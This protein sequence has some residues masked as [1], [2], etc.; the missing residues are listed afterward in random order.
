METRTVVCLSD[1]HLRRRGGLPAWCLRRLAEAD[2]ILHAGDLVA[3]SLLEELMQLAPVTA[4]HGNMDA[5]VLR[6]RLPARDVIEIGGVKI[7]LLHDPGPALGRSAR[8]AQA[9]VGCDAIVYGHTH[10]PEIERL[11][12]RLILNPGSPTAPRST[13]GATMLE[14]TISSDQ[15]IEPVFI[16][17]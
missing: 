14:L 3:H 5:P 11:G 1:T 7:G 13:L 12:R 15:V 10:L 16:T 17:P 6:T 2:L 9:F 8:L 4:V